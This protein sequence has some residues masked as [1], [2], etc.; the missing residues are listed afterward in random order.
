MLENNPPDTKQRILDAAER[1]F[2]RDGYHQTSLRSITSEAEV[3]LAAVNYHFGSKEVLLEEVFKRRLIP[4]NAIRKNQLETVREQAQ[5]A[6]RRPEVGA[7]LR[8]F[9]VPTVR[10]C[11]EEPGAEH[12]S[13]LV[14]R[15]IAEPDDTVRNVFILHIMPLFNLLFSLLQEA[16][17]ELDRDTVFWRLHFA[18]GATTHTMRLLGRLDLLPEGL[19]RQIQVDVLLDQL[20]AFVTAGVRQP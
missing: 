12:F 6:Q 20:M 3:N 17:P 1:L 5:D 4:L 11:S 13:T 15:A 14:G 9:I 18:L 8:A 10:F 7:V 2:A 16:L 19:N